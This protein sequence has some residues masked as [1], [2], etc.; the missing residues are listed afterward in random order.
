[1][2]Q[3][4][5]KERN[6]CDR[7]VEKTEMNKKREKIRLKRRVIISDMIIEKVYL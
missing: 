7:K 1:M 4:K 3:S 5:I 6:W 2:V